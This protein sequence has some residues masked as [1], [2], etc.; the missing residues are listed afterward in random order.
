[1]CSRALVPSPDNQLP[2]ADHRATVPLPHRM[3]RRLSTGARRHVRGV[4][5]LV[6]G[7]LCVVPPLI[8]ATPHQAS[9]P[10]IRLNRGFQAP[11]AKWHVE[12]ATEILL[13]SPVAETTTPVT[14]RRVHIDADE[15]NVLSAPDFSPDP[16]R[17]P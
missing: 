3:T 8:R 12:P 17:G 16:L 4:I 15:G 6:V 13:S 5:F 1:M 7:V 10:Q 9:K 14:T 2:I 11:P